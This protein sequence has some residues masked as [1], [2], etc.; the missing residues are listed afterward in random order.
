MDVKHMLAGADRK[1]DETS[2]TLDWQ[3]GRWQAGDILS[4]NPVVCIIANQR[5][6]REA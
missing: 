6:A 2:W 5:P 1:Y 3:A 4:G